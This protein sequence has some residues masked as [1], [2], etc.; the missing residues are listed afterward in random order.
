M[1]ESKINEPPGDQ[2]QQFESVNVLQIV[3][4]TYRRK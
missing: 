4:L 2:I 3:W 1:D